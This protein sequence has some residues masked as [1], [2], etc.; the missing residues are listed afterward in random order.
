MAEVKRKAVDDC[1]SITAIIGI[2]IMMLLLSS[3]VFAWTVILP[4]VGLLYLAGFLP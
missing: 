1:S 3:M 4:V 2:G